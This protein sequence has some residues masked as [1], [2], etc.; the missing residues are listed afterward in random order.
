MGHVAAAP[1]PIACP[2]R[3]AR[4]RKAKGP[5]LTLN[6]YTNL[7]G[8]K[9]VMYKMDRMGGRGEKGGPKIVL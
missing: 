8:E 3:S 2:S 4:A 7:L 6:M 5:N 9:M 1:G